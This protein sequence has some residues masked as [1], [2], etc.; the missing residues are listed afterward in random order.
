VR[1]Y[2]EKYYYSYLRKLPDEE[3][4]LYVQAVYKYIKILIDKFGADAILSLNYVA[5]PHIM[6]NLYAAKRGIPMIAVTDSKVRGIYI[7]VNGYRD[8]TG[9]FYDRVDV[10]N[11]GKITSD[12]KKK[13][14]EYI[15]Q[16]RDKFINPD[17]SKKKKGG[18]WPRLKYHLKPYAL[19]FN[20]YRYPQINGMKNLGITIDY[21][22]PRIIFRD[23]LAH[24][25]NRFFLEH[26]A[27]DQ[28]IGKKKYA[29]FPL[30][31]QPESNIDAMSP[32]YNNQLDL[33]RQFALALPGDYVLAVKEHPEMVGLRSLSFYKK[34]SR[35]PNVH[36]IDHRI[37]SEEVLKSAGVVLSIN[38][39]AIAEAAFLNIPAIQVG[40]L[41]T[42][43]K[44]PN[45]VRHTD[46]TTLSQKIK[47]VLAT[48]Q[49]GNEY[50]RRLENFVAA[51]YDTGFYHS[52]D[53]AESMRNEGYRTQLWQVY[54]K[55]L[56]RVL[57]IP[58]HHS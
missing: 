11:S 53:Y 28:V 29:Y 40:D 1:S 8:D 26:F 2:G 39:T 24:T 12:N 10:L 34:L 25:R 17:Y 52:F 13:A 58:Q 54:K 23:Y 30:Q 36:L 47:Q 14:Q 7:F 3:I 20:F 19:M 49:S 56:L 37:P 27:Y 48:P 45:V 4:L 57:K 21:C 6:L 46:M 15:A 50:E 44:L 43:Q 35:T 9:E 38:G 32:Y 42:T 55:E 51:A 16:F 18:L 33:A 5:L 22:P 31:F 41:G